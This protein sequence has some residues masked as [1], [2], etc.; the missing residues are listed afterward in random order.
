MLQSMHALQVDLTRYLVSRRQHPDR[1][2]RIDG[3][4]GSAPRVHLHES[5]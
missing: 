1:L 3:M 4:N 5:A 2:I